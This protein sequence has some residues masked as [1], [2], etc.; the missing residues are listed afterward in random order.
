[1]HRSQGRQGSPTNRHSAIKAAARIPRVDLEYE[2]ETLRIDH[3]LRDHLAANG[4]QRR[5]PDDER[6]RAHPSPFT[7]EE[8]EV[9][10]GELSP[11]TFAS[12]AATRGY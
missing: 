9:A 2:G 5:L 11:H 7:L 1:M 12:K 8:A 3:D 6:I 10:T 4:Q